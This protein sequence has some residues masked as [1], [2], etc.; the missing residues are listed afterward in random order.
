[1]AVSVGCV[2]K[3]RVRVCQGVVP[4][5]MAMPGSG[6]DRGFV[7]VLVVF[8]M[9]VIVLVRHRFVGVLVLMAFSQMKPSA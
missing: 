4:V 7:F 2:R 1:M 6:C 5:Q 3:V 8:V 9:Y